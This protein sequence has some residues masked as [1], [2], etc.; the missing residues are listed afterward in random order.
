[1]NE[2]IRKGNAALAAHNR[3]LAAD[4]YRLALEDPTADE[5]TTRIAA[6]RISELF[7]GRVYR[8]ST[9]LYHRANC[10]AQ[11]V[12][13]PGNVEWFDSWRDAAAIELRPCS[14]CKPRPPKG[15]RS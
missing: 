9:Y 13:L 11:N 5:I 3:A 12:T 14:Q 8:S 7:P 1:M 15:S 4:E 2:H 6:N 10:G